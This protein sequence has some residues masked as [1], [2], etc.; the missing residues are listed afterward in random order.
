[1]TWLRNHFKRHRDRKPWSFCW[2]VS[3]EGT[4]ISFVVAAVL[5]NLFGPEAR[6]VFD[7]PFLGVVLAVLVIAPVGETVVF[8]LIPI[9]IGRLLRAR[10]AIQVAVSAVLLGL[11]HLAEGPLVGICA[12]IIGGPY[13]AFTYAHWAEK[14]QALSV[15]QGAR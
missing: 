12:G 5:I 14:S 2:R 1:M 15:F 7:L 8:Q 9:L 10:F 6:T 4:I 13:L 11:A 3:V